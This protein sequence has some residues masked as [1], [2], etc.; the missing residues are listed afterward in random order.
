MSSCGM[1]MTII[2][3]GA[4]A[5]RNG[6]CADRDAGEKPDLGSPFITM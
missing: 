1:H 5:N 4:L 6:C 2:G 3:M